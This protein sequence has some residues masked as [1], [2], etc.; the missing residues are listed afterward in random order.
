LAA[1]IDQSIYRAG[2]TENPAARGDD[3][4]VVASRLRLSLVAPIESAIVEQPAKAER[5]VK[6]WVTVVWASF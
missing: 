4:A 6:P 1:N 5:N 3:L 2:S